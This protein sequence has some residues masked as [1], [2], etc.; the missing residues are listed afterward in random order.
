VHLIPPLQAS[1]GATQVSVIP[2]HEAWKSRGLED[3]RT[4]AYT[5][6]IERVGQAYIEAGIHP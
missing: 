3:L 2:L 6:A 1:P 4:A 5:L